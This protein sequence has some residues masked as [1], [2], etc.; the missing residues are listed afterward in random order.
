MIEPTGHGGPASPAA[1]D[2]ATAPSDHSLLRRMRAGQADAATHIYLRYAARLLTLAQRQCGADLASRV[3]PEDIVQ[4]VFRTFFRRAVRGHYDVP[5]GEVLWKLFLVIALNKVRRLG[6]HHRAARRDVRL[7]ASG[8]RFD[9]AL[10][11]TPAR[12]ELALTTLRL[13]VDE[14]L[15]AL[16]ESQR[17]I[18]ELRIEGHAVEEIANQTGRAKRSVERALQEFRCKLSAVIDEDS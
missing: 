1:S 17:A 9:Q 10:E 15:E 11:S 2:S 4:S 18:I 13:V 8:N 7:T 14:I 16:P 6:E 12:D 5:E 3:D